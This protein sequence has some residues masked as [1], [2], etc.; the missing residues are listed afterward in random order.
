MRSQLE[1]PPTINSQCFHSCSDSGP[2]EQWAMEPPGPTVGAQLDW[3]GPGPGAWGVENLTGGCHPVS[4]AVISCSVHNWAVITLWPQMGCRCD[5]V[6]LA[7]PCLRL[8]TTCL[9][10]VPT[11]HSPTANTGATASCINPGQHP[12]TSALCAAEI[13]AQPGTRHHWI[14]LVL[15]CKFQLAPIL[16]RKGAGLPNQDCFQPG[17]Q[18]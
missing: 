8:L 11:L 3:H 4:Q 14:T 15:S 10:P 1:S 5:Y 17:Q 13:T 2:R 6:L 7:S 9:S 18:D 12:F 16:A